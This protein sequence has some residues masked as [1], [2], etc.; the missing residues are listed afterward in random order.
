M[1]ALLVLARSAVVLGILLVAGG[2]LE[3]RWRS[4][5]ARTVWWSTLCFAVLQLLDD[6]LL[7][8]AGTSNPLN[9]EIPYQDLLEIP[10]LALLVVVFVGTL[11]TLPFRLVR[12]RVS[13]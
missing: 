5:A 4:L 2:R 6:H 9:L 11:V 12:M 7:D 10:V 13:A 1:R 8:Q 3:A